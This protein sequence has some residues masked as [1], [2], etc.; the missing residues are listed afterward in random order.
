MTTFSRVLLN[1]QKRDARKLLTNRQAMHAA[2][3]AAFPPD[4]E[5]RTGRVLWRLDV[6]GHAHTLYIVA[7]EAPELTHIVEQAG[8]ATRP[9]D[10]ADYSRML[11]SV[12]DGREFAFRLTGNPVHREAAADS[13][14]GAL[15]PHVTAAQ[16]LRWL[17]AKSQQH[18][19]S[20]AERGSRGQEE[21]RATVTKRED[22]S[23]S[24]R[25]D[26]GTGTVT[27]RTAQF[28]GVLTVTDAATMREALT[29]GIGRAKAYGC[30]LLTLAP[31]RKR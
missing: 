21:V 8:W 26:G 16:Q 14:R 20:I 10:T 2:V 23:F 15:H 7:P 29:H 25:H 9:G 3:R 17:E 28:D 30:G 24:R 31:S 13:K 5:A 18:G 1:P 19:F 12:V 6:D 11:A 22:L 27:L 4:L